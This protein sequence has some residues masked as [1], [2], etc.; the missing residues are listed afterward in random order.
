MQ[1]LPA[2]RLEPQLPVPTLKGD[3]AVTRI[4]ESVLLPGLPIVNASA[5]LLVP[6]STIPK[7]SVPGV[8]VNSAPG[9]PVPSSPVTTGV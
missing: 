5:P 3:K 8:T 6:V 7:F 1:L 2:P 9:T 4:P